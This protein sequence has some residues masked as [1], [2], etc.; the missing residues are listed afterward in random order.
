MRRVSAHGFEHGESWMS[1]LVSDGTIMCID[2][3]PERCYLHDTFGLDEEAIHQPIRTATCDQIRPSTE[4]VGLGRL[5]NLAVSETQDHCAPFCVW[6]GNVS[7]GSLPR[8]EIRVVG[9][10][11]A[12]GLIEE[13]N[14]LEP[15]TGL[16][17]TPQSR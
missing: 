14:N 8:F 12:V 2:A 9:F 7:R 6:A 3:I 16:P 10:G 17:E 1:R 11:R 4:H 5:S 15:E 13:S